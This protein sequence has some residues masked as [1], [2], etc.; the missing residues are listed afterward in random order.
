[1][2]R[3]DP[4]TVTSDAEIPVESQTK[5]EIGPNFTTS[6]G[7]SASWSTGRAGDHH[8]LAPMHYEPKY[9]Y[10][11]IV[12]LPGRGGT[13]R[14]ITQVM[15]WISLRNHVGVGVNGVRCVQATRPESGYQWGDWSG[16]IERSF[17]VVETAI[18]ASALRFHIAPSRIFLVGNGQGGTLALRLAM[19]HP[20]RFA[21]AVSIGGPLPRGNT[22]FIRLTH[23]RKVPL[24]MLHGRDSQSCGVDQVCQDLR[25]MHTA[26]LKVSV[27]QYPCG[28]EVTT[29][30]LADINAW[31]ME[32]V[33]GSPSEPVRGDC[34]LSDHN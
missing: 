20:G 16:D 17:E 9:A 19:G 1:M 2:N 4:W 12:W 14:E 6:S 3:L 15:P 21:G 5:E 23:A 7:P 11:L 13:A 31:L 24:L 18:E 8:V 10:P 32:R 34:G 25:L 30:M 22:P 29:Q 27:R 28:N 33:T 26:G